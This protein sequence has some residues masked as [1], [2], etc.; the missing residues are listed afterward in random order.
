MQ[1]WWVCVS[2]SL[3]H[4]VQAAMCA[5]EQAQET[6]RSHTVTHMRSPGTSANTIT[7]VAKA[8]AETDTFLSA[9][10]DSQSSR[11][12]D[13]QSFCVT[14]GRQSFCLSCGS[15][16]ETWAWKCMH[17]VGYQSACGSGSVALTLDQIHEMN[18]T[19]A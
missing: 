16:A 1:S 8:T 4:D 5:Y 15:E 13:S 3:R 10:N 12:I 14:F 9:S 17:K 6:R 2:G 18:R 11:S 7:N 19:R